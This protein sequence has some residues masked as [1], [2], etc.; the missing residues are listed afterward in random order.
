MNQSLTASIQEAIRD[1]V[2]TFHSVISKK[3]GLNLIDLNKLWIGYV[4]N[5]D[6]EDISVTYYK[7]KCVYS[8]SNIKC[9]KRVSSN[10]KHGMYCS[11]HSEAFNK[12]D[13]SNEYIKS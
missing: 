2:Y 12:I 7:S 8:C 3:H 13:V 1:S 10:C 11:R 6:S 5:T 4:N 9:G